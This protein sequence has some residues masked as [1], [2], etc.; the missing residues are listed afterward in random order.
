[1]P[2]TKVVANIQL[3]LHAKFYIF[4]NSLNISSQFILICLENQIE[5][6]F[7]LEKGGLGCFPPWRPASTAPWPISTREPAYLPLLPRQR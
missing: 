7:K 2:N 3:Y 6:E 1:V 4:P 5:N